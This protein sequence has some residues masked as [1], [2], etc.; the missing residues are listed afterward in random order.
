MNTRKTNRKQVIK[1]ELSAKISITMW[2]INLIIK[3]QRLAE[4]INTY[5]P[6]I[7]FL[8]ETLQNQQ[9]RQLKVNCGKR[10]TVKGC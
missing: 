9:H 3:R 10:N 6:T 7:C 4:Q 2:T 1:C 5:K 8:Q